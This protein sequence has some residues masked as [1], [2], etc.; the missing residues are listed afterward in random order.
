MARKGGKFQVGDR[1][2]MKRSYGKISKG[3]TVEITKN[4]GKKRRRTQVEAKNAQHIVEIFS[5]IYL[6]KR[7]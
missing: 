7:V 3:D 4:L 1:F 2:I 6:G 5:A